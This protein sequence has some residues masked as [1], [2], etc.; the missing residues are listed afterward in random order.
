MILNAEKVMEDEPDQKIVE[1]Q[2]PSLL[3]AILSASG[4]LAAMFFF[5][6]LFMD[7]GVSFML[8]S[9]L[10]N[11][12]FLLGAGAVIAVMRKLGL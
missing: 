3:I 5:A 11:W 6:G 8:E 10:R 1:G 4:I 12:H 2:Q 7:R 9:L